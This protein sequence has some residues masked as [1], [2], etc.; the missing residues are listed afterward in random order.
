MRLETPP[1]GGVPDRSEDALRT[2]ATIATLIAHFPGDM[3]PEFQ[4]ATV[5]FFAEYAETT[6]KAVRWAIGMARQSW[7]TVLQRCCL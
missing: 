5:T 2:L 3:G 1:A 4:E 7:R 6:L